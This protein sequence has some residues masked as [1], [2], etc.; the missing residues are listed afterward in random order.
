MVDKVRFVENI[1]NLLNLGQ[2]KP[3]ILQYVQNL[4]V[5]EKEAKELVAEAEKSSQINSKAIASIKP[6]TL[7]EQI[8]RFKK[9]RT[10]SGKEQFK[11]NIDAL[12]QMMKKMRTD[13]GESK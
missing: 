5:S 11:E 10:E 9:Q 3:E 8:E 12:E 7:G 1:R 6:L 4:G 2:G 13:M